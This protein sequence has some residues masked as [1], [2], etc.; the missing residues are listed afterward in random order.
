MKELSESDIQTIADYIESFIIDNFEATNQTEKLVIDEAFQFRGHPYVICATGDYEVVDADFMD[1]ETTEY[2]VKQIW[3]FDVSI[4][5]VSSDETKTL[6]ADV[7]QGLINN[8]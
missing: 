7:I 8:K 5:S 4:T 1:D 6:D 2:R 3:L